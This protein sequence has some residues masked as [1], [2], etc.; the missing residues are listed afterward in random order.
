MPAPVLPGEAPTATAAPMMAASMVAVSRALTV[1]SP[2]W[3]EP[4]PMTL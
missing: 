2:T 1:T 3:L 4:V